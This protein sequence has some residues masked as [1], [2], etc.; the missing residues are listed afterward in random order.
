MRERGERA[1]ARLAFAAAID[2]APGYV[3]A[4]VAL[5]ALL[6][7][8]RLA[9]RAAAICEDGLRHA[10]DDVSLWRALGL[11]RLMQHDASAA[12]AER[13]GAPAC[14]RRRTR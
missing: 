8:E 6:R 5:A 7:E 10:P 14:S 2:A 1:E 12:R 11:A 9:A 4:R 3:E 13:S